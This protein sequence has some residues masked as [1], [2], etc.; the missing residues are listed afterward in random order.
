VDEAR[1]AYV[2]AGDRVTVL[3][4]AATEQGAHDTGLEGVVTEMARAVDTDQRTVAVKVGLP[5]TVTTRTGSFARVVFRGAPR[6]ALLVPAHAI[7][8]NG[9]VSS[10][11]VVRDGVAAMRL[12]RVGT[13]SPQGVE[14]LAG[15]AAGESIVVSPPAGL[16]DGARVTAGRGPART[17]R[18]S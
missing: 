9:Q 14:V 12:V 13:A 2:H 7:Q 6:Q 15:L 5:S 11:Y 17:G 16:A 3:I 1:A 10:V 18:R 4:D 8:R